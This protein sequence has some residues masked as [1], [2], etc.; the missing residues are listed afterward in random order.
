MGKGGDTTTQTST[1]DL[2]AYIKPYVTDALAK[3][4]AVSNQQYTPYEDPRLANFSGTT[5]NAFDMIRSSAN[6][7]AHGTP[8]VNAALA[9]AKGIEG[10]NA[11]PITSTN[12]AQGNAGVGTGT[13]DFKGIP[14][15]DIASYMNPYTE[16]V[17]DVQKNRLNQ[18]FEEQQ[19]GRDASAVAAG[20]FGGDRRFVA[21]SLANRDRND[22]L[23]GIEATGL[24]S[25]FDRATSLFSSD[26]ARRQAGFESGQGRNLTAATGN[27][28]RG[29]SAQI[30]SEDA[31]RQG[32]ALGLDAARTAGTLSGERQDMQLRGA[33]ALSGVGAKIQQRQQAGL[34]LAYQDFQNQRDWPS[35]QLQLYSQLLNGTPVTPSTTTSTT[36]PAPSF[37]SQLAGLGL[38]GA[39]VYD[40]LNNGNGSSAS[41]GASGGA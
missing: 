40:L 20:A 39:G 33:E 17:L 29:L 35:K 8:D 36:T 11:A 37:L 28:D 6:S 34:D 23:Q 7:T 1:G 9:T 30:A 19:A 15:A 2:P 14:D 18:S 4:K 22:Q 27:A 38:S 25:A 13:F 10:Y 26:E 21:D 12:V 16:N 3:G 31:R 24:Q 5:Q 32:K 41:G